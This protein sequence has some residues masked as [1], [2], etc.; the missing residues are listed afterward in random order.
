V[1]DAF[2]ELERHAALWDEL[3][4]DAPSPV[5]QRSWAQAWAETIGRE[6]RAR[7]VVAD[8]ALAPLVDRRSHWELLGE[9]ELFEPMDVLGDAAALVA[10]LRRL[11]RPVVFRR[12]PASSPLVSLGRAIPAAG[13]PLLM[14]PWQPEKRHASDLRR[15][16]RRAE[17]LG[18]VAIDVVPTADALDEAFD[19]EARS[20]RERQGTILARDAERGA[21]YRRYAQFAEA[22]GEL[23]VSFLRIGGRAAAM[24]IM[25]ER[26]RRV[27]LLKIAY[28]EELARCSPGQ[29]LLED[30]VRDAQA[31][32]L[33]AVEF[34]GSAAPWTRVWTKREHEY[35]R[36]LAWR[37]LP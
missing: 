30:T 3:A 15:A 10:P 20:W 28:D 17:A 24:Q 35:V 2:A 37:L 13:A 34:L 32:G 8:G 9:R 11:R 12:L 31:R 29:L 1:A 6:R 21:F 14:L 25:V 18:E 22:S 5:L 36:V 4:R 16:R 26:A 27:W 7:F 33:E 23:R 19:V